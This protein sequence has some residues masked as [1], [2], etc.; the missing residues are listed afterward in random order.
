M[1]GSIYFYPDRHYIGYD[2][3]PKLMR[4][5]TTNKEFRLY[6]NIRELNQTADLLICRQVMQHWPNSE[7]TYFMDEV[8]PRFKYALIGNDEG[9]ADRPDIPF[10]GWAPVNLDAWQPKEPVHS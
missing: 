2:V 10:G 9:P 1:T 4:P 7:I 8:V 6:S 3:V 5:N